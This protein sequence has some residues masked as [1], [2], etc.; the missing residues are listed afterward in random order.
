LVV[1]RATGVTLA[2]AGLLLVLTT[3]AQR[4]EAWF[5]WSEPLET[6]IRHR[7]SALDARV[8]VHALHV[9]TGRQ[10]AINADEPMNTV[11]VI[12]IP[13]MILAYRDAE[14]GLLHLD[15][16]Y[17][18]T[19]DDY[20]RGSGLIQT[21]TPGLHPTIGDLVRQMIVTSDNIGTDIVLHRVGLTRVNEM[22]TR[23]GYHQTRIN[24]TTGDLARRVFVLA[25][26]R[27]STFTDRELYQLGLPPV[28]EDTLHHILERVAH[29]RTEWLGQSTAREMSRLLLELLRGELTSAAT[30]E[31]MLEIL[32]GQVYDSRLPRFL[33]EEA[34]VAHKTGEALP[35]VVNDAGII[36]HAGGPT[37]VTVFVNRNKGSALQVE[38]VIGR[39]AQDLVSAWGTR[40]Q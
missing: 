32:R 24:K 27:Y 40:H 10:V 28:A 6:L 26:P 21:F 22:L 8:S 36:F 1:R 3:A 20:R 9:P 15:E 4:T 13:I 19:R 35:Y 29:D 30:A 37:V 38:E 34:L 5:L 17:E 31:E 25:D 18:V 2:L 12:K 39:I 14:A 11:S 23:F 16:R 7:L 33:K